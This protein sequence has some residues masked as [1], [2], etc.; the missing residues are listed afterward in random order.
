MS[1]D[2]FFLVLF[3][4]TFKKPSVK[5]VNGVQSEEKGRKCLQMLSFG[6]ENRA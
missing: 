6:R 4:C 1:K 3:F 2:A 5:D